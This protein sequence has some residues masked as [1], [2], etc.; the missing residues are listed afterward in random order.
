MNVA[1]I[2]RMAP[3][4]RAVV[5]GARLG[6][7]LLLFVSLGWAVPVLGAEEKQEP[8]PP[9]SEPMSAPSQPAPP[10]S[11]AATSASDS[12]T[13]PAELPPRR[14]VP[15]YRQL[16]SE[17]TTAGDVLIWVPRV[18]LLPAYLVTEYALR[19][20]VGGARVT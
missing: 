1:R 12:T 2:R 20:P 18:I 8:T 15:N 11:D 9:A 10:P 19:A 6:R 16:D 17:A 5:V 4:P 13:P 14:D 7:A 3:V